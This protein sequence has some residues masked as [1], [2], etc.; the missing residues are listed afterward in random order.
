VAAT[1]PASTDRVPPAALAV[2]RVAVSF[3]DEYRETEPFDPAA[4]REDGTYR[5]RR[6]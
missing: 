6:E 5:L 4:H 2:K 1:A 3:D